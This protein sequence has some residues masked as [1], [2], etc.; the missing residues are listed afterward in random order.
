MLKR[1]NSAL[2]LRGDTSELVI[3]FDD[4]DYPNEVDAVLRMMYGVC[5]IININ[6]SSVFKQSIQTIRRE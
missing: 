3:G 5:G 2:E 1:K 6:L 4:P